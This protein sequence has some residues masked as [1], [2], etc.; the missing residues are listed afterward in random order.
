MVALVAV[1]DI[2]GDVLSPSWPVVVFTHNPE[3]FVMAWVAY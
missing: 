3:H 2:V 1:L